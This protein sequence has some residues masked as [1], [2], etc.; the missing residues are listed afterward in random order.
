[1]TDQEQYQQLEGIAIAYE[2]LKEKHYKVIDKYF[3]LTM[4]YSELA[5]KYT[6]LVDKLLD[7]PQ[8]KG[9]YMPDYFKDEDDR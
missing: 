2:E 1:M 6:K 5:D 4:K 7:A 8:P 3:E 9:V